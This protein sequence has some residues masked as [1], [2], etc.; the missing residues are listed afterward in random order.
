MC[1]AMSR[2]RSVVVVV[3]TVVGVVATSSLGFWQLRRADQKIA[4]HQTMMARQHLP[5]LGNE[6]L[7]CEAAGWLQAEQ[8][9]VALRGAWLSQYTIFLDNRS[10]DGRAGFLV[11]T[12]LKLAPAG[13]APGLDRCGSQTVLVQRGWVPRDM[14]D[15]T[16]LPDVPTATGEIELMGRLV[17]PPSKLMDLGPG[18]QPAGLVRQNVDV[19]DLSR[20]W[21]LTLRPGS[22]QQLQP[23]AAAGA[24][25][26]ASSVAPIG[27]IPGVDV[28]GLLRHWWQP[29]AE[30]GKHQAYAAQ[31]FAMAAVMA[32]LYVWFQWLKPLRARGSRSV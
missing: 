13:D 10:M 7:P 23:L 8:R 22:I 19:S 18:A 20:E 15:R 31:W 32:A 24:G 16:K 12:P 9:H 11:L 26:R 3:A 27:A 14:L 29:S 28:D 2:L 6:A 25:T 5:P 17:P 30:V 4:I 1:M 21:G